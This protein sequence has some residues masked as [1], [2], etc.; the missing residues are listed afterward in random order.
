M[1]IRHVL[2]AIL[3]CAVAAHSQT[4]VYPG[5]VVTDSQLKVSRNLLQTTLTSSQAAADTILIVSSTANF[6]PNMLVS[7]GAEIENICGV[8]G[9]NILQV[10][11]SSCPNID[12]RG[13]DTAHGGGAAASHPSGSTVS[14]F[15]TAWHVNALDSEV[16][17]IEGTLG[18]NLANV[19]A[20]PALSAAQ[21]AFGPI[22]SG[23]GVSVSGGNLV[24]GNNTLTFTT[25]PLGVN[26]TDANHYMYFSA[27]TGTAEDCLITGGSGTAGQANGQIIVNCGNT[28]SG[29]WTVQ[30]DAG[31]IREACQAKAPARVVLP[32][33][34][35]NVYQT[36]TL[37]AGCLIDGQVPPSQNGPTSAVNLNMQKAGVAMFSLPNAGAGV[38]NA[39]INYG[40][41]PSYL[42]NGSP[43]TS[44]ST[45]LTSSINAFVENVIFHGFYV[46]LAATSGTILWTNVIANNAVSDCGQLSGLGAGWVFNFLAQGCGGNGITISPLAGAPQFTTLGAFNTGGWGVKVSTNSGN[47]A[48]LQG[49]DWD[50]EENFSGNLLLDSLSS[51]SVILENVIAQSG[52]TTSSYGTNNTAPCVR[53]ASTTANMFMPKSDVAIDGCQGNGLEADSN[54]TTVGNAK[55]SG[56]GVGAQA[57][58]TYGIE[59]S[60]T[61][62]RISNAEV[63]GNDS[64]FNGATSHISNND[65]SGNVTLGSSFR[66][67]FSDNTITSGTL[68]LTSGCQ[69]SYGRNYISG[70]PS[71]QSGSCTDDG[72]VVTTTINTCTATAT[73]GAATCNGQSGTV[74]SESLTTAAGSS[75]SLTLSDSLITASSVVIGVSG[76]GTN[77]GGA[78]T[79][80]VKC[81][82][83]SGTA[84]CVAY[85]DGAT[86]FNGT[87]KIIFIIGNTNY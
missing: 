69:W 61:S 55:I 59:S 63:F 34:S 56:A 10:G 70:G 22:T 17:A 1:R 3:L 39:A 58:H 48:P 72:S 45:G 62:I 54:F 84:T 41:P 5:A 6:A 73:A 16:K 2:P 50:V 66:G 78:V 29:A 25:V 49:N 24:V 15:V 23:S 38:I 35:Y 32:P 13:F 77:T 47:A 86:P 44:G 31:G 85:N 28:H 83:G 71:N 75:Y 26:G 64:L 76:N 36:I 11:I 27:G 46:D 20:S 8:S 30:S 12:G 9:S 52:G 87:I 53:L 18:A 80:H 60:G 65:F 37:P 74:T 7:V 82:P 4:A 81:T 42:V 19:P 21:Y 14:L 43:A 68:T 40:T 51:F 79:G 33:G 67:Q 57:G